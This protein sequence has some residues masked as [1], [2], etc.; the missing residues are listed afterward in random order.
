[1]A[2]KELLP[3]ELIGSR[4][5][6]IRG[7]RVIIDADLAELYEVE[8][9]ALNQAVRR[10]AER[11]PADFILTL[12]REEIAVISEM[13]GSPKRRRMKF[14]KS[15]FAFTEYGVAMLSSV[16]NSPRAIA[17]NIEIMR[18]FSR[19]RGI[20]AEHRE[21][22]ARLDV[23]EKRYDAQFKDVFIAIRQLM[24]PPAK[25]PKKIGF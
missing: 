2:K 13:P 1:M 17:A 14:S 9:R 11:F 4:I 3:A 25:P 12:S 22:L 6:T 10:N 15:A 20:L 24:E 21:L 23:P 19:L 16:L 8:T 5:I 7:H 18:A